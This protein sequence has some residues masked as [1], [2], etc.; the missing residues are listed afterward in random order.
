M[1]LDHTIEELF[2]RAVGELET[3]VETLERD[4]DDRALMLLELVDAVHRPALELILA[5]EVDHPVAR[6]VLSMYDL[7][8]ASELEQVELALDDL[9]PYIE[10]HGGKLELLSVQ[11]G[12]VHIRMSGSCDGCAASAI[13]LRRGIEKR[14]RERWPPFVEVIAHEPEPAAEP[15]RTNGASPSRVLILAPRPAFRDALTVEELA[16]AK[17]I[18]VDVEGISVLLLEV[19]GEPYAYRNR[20][21]AEPTR[22]LPLEGGRLTGPVLVCP[23]HNCAFSATSG[24]RVDDQPDGDPLMSVP[25][26][27]SGGMIQVAV[28]VS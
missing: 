9:R 8:D 20:C 14:L 28:N 15:V 16:T 18:S 3:L 10:S 26:A 11:D 13:T 12:V 7:V 24:Y 17:K 6:A 21:P 27:V 19:D 1:E 25:V 2:D 4:G 5:G 22:P 23:W